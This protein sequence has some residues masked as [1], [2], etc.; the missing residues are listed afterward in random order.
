MRPNFS[1]FVVLVFIPAYVLGAFLFEVLTPS[2]GEV[3]DDR[4]FTISFV[5]DM[6][7]DRYIRARAQVHGYPAI[8]EGTRSM[9]DES[10]VIVGNLEGPISTLSPVA[11]WPETGPNH[12][13]FT[14]ATTV[15]RTLF[16][17]GFRAVSLANNHIYDFGTEGYTQTVRW[18][19][20]AGVGYFGSPHDPYTPWRYEVGGVPVALYAYDSW[21]VRDIE[22][23]TQRVSAEPEEVFVVV[24]AHWGDEY[25]SHPN[26]GQRNAA[27]RF[28][29]AGAD[30]V[31]GSHPHVIQTK[32]FYKDKWIYYSLGNFVF[33]QYFSEAVQCGAVL[34]VMLSPNLTYTTREEF[35]FLERDG[36]TKQSDCR[37]V[38]PLE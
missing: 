29:D 3:E 22:T 9:F 28:I 37:D 1:V 4:V 14:F 7:F 32:E 19:G 30:L 2:S 25:E 11:D 13:Q 35:I 27:R 18:L 6:M 20:E 15:A 34:H 12:Y 21:H 5:G 10:V 31:V 24:Y 16:D 36:T 23:I 38:V 26:S 17:A 8:F 33:D